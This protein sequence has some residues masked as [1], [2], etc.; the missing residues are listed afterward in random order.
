MALLNPHENAWPFGELRPFSYDLAMIDF[1][2]PFEARS[3]K[4]EEKSFAKHYG[5]MTWEEIWAM[6][7]FVGQL[8]GRDGVAFL[9]A[10]WPHVFYGG[11]PRNHFRGADASITKVGITIKKIG[12]R[13]VGGGAWHKKTIHGKTAFGTGHRVRSSC[14]PFFLCVTGNPDTSRAERNLI[15]GLR[16]E[17]S[18]KPENAYSW[19]ERYLPGA[20]RVDLFSRQKRPG[21]D[22][23]GYEAG[24][25]EPIIAAAH[26]EAA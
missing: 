21:W 2:W 22:N 8:L 5:A 26:D 1:P 12:L 15:E 9:W 23:W 6:A 13:F 10:T 20:R 14:E 7:P 3:P 19:C 18:R 16:R 25:F 4:G 17:H 24:K 11:D